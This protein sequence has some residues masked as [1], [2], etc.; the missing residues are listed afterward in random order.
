MMRAFRFFTPAPRS[1]KNARCRP[2]RTPRSCATPPVRRTTSPSPGRSGSTWT[3]APPR[4]TRRARRPYRRSPSCV[5]PSVSPHP[6]SWRLGAAC[7]ATGRSR[8]TFLPSKPGSSASRSTPHSRPL[9]SSTTPAARRTL[10]A[11]CAP[12]APTG[13]KTEKSRWCC[14]A[15][16]S[17][18]RPSGSWRHW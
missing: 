4:T 10:P 9:G 5:A 6:C 16:P 2:R 15:T 8:K 14:C 18:S 7:T 17:P 11:S 12:R 13:A 3:S 1:P